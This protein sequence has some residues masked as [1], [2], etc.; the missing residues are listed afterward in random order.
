MIFMATPVFFS[1]ERD[2][3]RGHPI[4]TSSFTDGTVNVEATFRCVKKTGLQNG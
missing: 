4:D 3:S 1:G 2:P